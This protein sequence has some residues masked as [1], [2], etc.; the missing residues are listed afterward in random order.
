VSEKPTKSSDTEVDADATVADAQ[1]DW[2]EPT[3]ATVL[4]TDG[5]DIGSGTRTALGTRAG[6]QGSST[7]MY[8]TRSLLTSASVATDSRQA[9]LT[10]EVLR[11]R[12]FGWII[13]IFTVLT[14]LVVT[15]MDGHPTAKLLF[16]IG[17]GLYT[18]VALALTVAIY[19]DPAAYNERN[20]SLIAVFALPAAYAGVYFWGFFSPAPIVIIMALYF[21]SLVGGARYTLIVYLAIALLQGVLSALIIMGVMPDVGLMRV[22]TATT[23][24]AVLTQFLVQAVLLA[25]YVWSRSVQ[26]PTVRVIP[27]GCGARA[28]RDGRGLRGSAR[29]D[30]RLGGRQTAAAKRTVETGFRRALR[31]GSQAIGCYSLSSRGRHPRDRRPA[32]AIHRN[33]AAVRLRPC[34]LLT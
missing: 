3:P 1:T 5:A 24:N 13:C 11:A 27:A 4:S 34:S 8:A 15:L 25:T 7:G 28:R 33:G 6:T 26:R 17:L 21:N 10:D 30:G 16:L 22:E 19:R 31:A 20:L 9:M 32:A 29:R 23:S 12:A 14:G 18:L 2:E